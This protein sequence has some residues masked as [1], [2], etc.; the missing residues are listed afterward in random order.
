MENGKALKKLLENDIYLIIA[1]LIGLVVFF[2]LYPRQNP[3]SAVTLSMTPQ[4][5]INLSKDILETN[6]YNTTSLRPVAKLRRENSLLDTLDLE[7]GRKKVTQLFKKNGLEPLPAYYWRVQWFRNENETKSS[8]V[9][10]GYNSDDNAEAQNM[11]APLYTLGLTLNGR[12]WKIKKS[13]NGHIKYDQVN[14]KAF[15]FAV[16][17][18]IKPDSVR[19]FSEQ[20]FF[21]NIEDTSLAAH[22]LFAYNRFT[23]KIRRRSVSTIDPRQLEWAL[24]NNHDVLISRETTAL[25]A[26]Y[27]LQ[28]TPW[29]DQIFKVDTVITVAGTDGLVARVR[30][31]M[32]HT[33]H[34]QTVQPY[35]DITAGGGLVEMDAGFNN[36]H[37]AVFNWKQILPLIISISTYIL[38]FLFIAFVFIRKIDAKLFDSKTAITVGVIGWFLASLQILMG[39]LYPFPTL[40]QFTTVL[41]YF[42]I[43]VIP[44]FIGLLGAFLMFFL[45][46]TGESIVRTVLPSKIETFS[47]AIRGYFHN[48]IMGRVMIRSVSLAMILSGLFTVVIYFLPHIHLYSTDSGS[49]FLSDKVLLPFISILFS[50]TYF[51]L[52]TGFIVILGMSSYAYHFVPKSWSIYATGAIFGALLSIVPISASFSV[53]LMLGG[54]IGFTLA[55]IYWRFDFLTT[56]TSGMLFFLL[57]ESTSGWLIAGSPDIL[58][59][60]LVFLFITSLLVL[61]FWGISSKNTGENIPKYVPRY[62][63]ELTQRERMERELEIARSVQTS[64]LPRKNPILKNFEISGICHSALEVGGDYYDFVDLGDGKLGIAIADVSGKGIQAAFYMTLLKGFLQSLCHQIDS[65]ANLL[66]HINKLFYQNSERGTFISMIYGI[67]DSRKQ[68]FTFARA[69]HNPLVYKSSSQNKAKIYTPSGLALGMI[70]DGFFNEHI[71]DATIQLMEGDVI[72]L[73]TDGYSE[74]MNSSKDQFGDDELV[75][76]IE[77]N[78]SGT[79]EQIIRNITDNVHHF[80]NGARQHDDMTIVVLKFNGIQNS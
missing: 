45:F 27:Y 20:N 70:G 10:I 39:V 77:Q 9:Q 31:S 72:T 74:A 32:D 50:K 42:K 48:R 25:M 62:V 40:D 5:V 13:H 22:L 44:L 75:E 64:F 54:L 80:V 46:G 68:T 58:S 63:V 78:S 49:V 11:E 14:K 12:L 61:G 15:T 2:V 41:F 28:F 59:S 69:G 24:E 51:A 73:Y 17:N 47:M 16:K 65:P 71:T 66:C 52:L 43:L 36:S 23:Q 3:E 56:I 35:V 60:I 8:S 53:S 18:S 34:G 30:F 79:P 37:K 7:F 4:Q 38:L 76:A 29:K 26:R 57:F 55:F 19:W 1:G 33:I 6:K 21:K 67:L